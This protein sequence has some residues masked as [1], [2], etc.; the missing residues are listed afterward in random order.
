MYVALIGSK[1]CYSI[2][3]T[4]DGSIIDRKYRFVAIFGIKRYITLPILLDKSKYDC[5]FII[6]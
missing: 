2:T 1:Q 4:L 3:F 6:K 5:N